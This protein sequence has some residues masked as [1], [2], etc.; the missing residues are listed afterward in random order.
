[1]YFCVL[2]P[3]HTHAQMNPY[4]YTLQTY[5][6]EERNIISSW[7]LV[8]ITTISN[9]RISICAYARSHAHTL[10]LS[11]LQCYLGMRETLGVHKNPEGE[12]RS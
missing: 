6:V 12:T 3:A 2:V 8:F 10:S 9:S 11:L 7:T 5:A 4:E 1:M